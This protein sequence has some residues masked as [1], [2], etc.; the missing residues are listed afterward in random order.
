MRR[1]LAI[2]S[3]VGLLC[4]ALGCATCACDSGCGS[5]LS[6]C[7]SGHKVHGRC[8]CDDGPQYGCHFDMCCHA[9]GPLATPAV[10]PVMPLKPMPSTP[11]VAEPLKDMPKDV[12][13]KKEEE[14]QQ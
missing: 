4:G 12:S 13:P 10:Q 2:C 9:H 3:A 7:G 5:G 14:Q 6:G 8:D 11:P 1:L